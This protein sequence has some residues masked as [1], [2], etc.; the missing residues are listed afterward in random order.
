MSLNYTIADFISRFI[1]GSS[2]HLR[3]LVI[4]SNAKIIIKI[5]I[6]FSNQGLISSFSVNDGFIKIYY[7]YRFNKSVFRD[8]EL[9]S[10][11]SRR[12]YC[13]IKSLSKKFTYGNFSGFYI[14][15]T[16]N[17]LIVTNQSLFDNISGEI[18][19]RI[20]I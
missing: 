19:L 5:L 15:S 9:I 12:I 2:R 10:R 13:N 17:G 20:R 18:L 8:I 7:K 6:I 3:F 14:I 11:P 16:S 1:T 4:R